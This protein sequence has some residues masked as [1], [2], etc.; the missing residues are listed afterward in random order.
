MVEVT[1]EIY[2]QFLGFLDPSKIKTQETELQEIAQC[3][4]K[5]NGCP[6]SPFGAK[7]DG[8]IRPINMAIITALP[9]KLLD[10]EINLT[11]I[12]EKSNGNYLAV[13]VY[14]KST[15]KHYLNE[16][17]VEQIFPEINS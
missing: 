13:A 9:R 8:E 14:D 1:E 10:N 12:A 7:I 5:C 6:G 11:I 2:E 16:L 17:V 15:R 3:G 4:I